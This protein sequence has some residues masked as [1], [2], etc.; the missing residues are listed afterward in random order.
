MAVNKQPLLNECP[1][2]LHLL[3]LVEAPTPTYIVHIERS[4]QG[5]A[6]LRHCGTLALK[7]EHLKTQN[8][9]KSLQC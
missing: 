7:S 4:N 8:I 3:T 6:I 1:Q 9:F 5:H 2:M